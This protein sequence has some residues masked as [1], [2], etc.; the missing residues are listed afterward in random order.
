MTDNQ[1]DSKV[2]PA[3][4]SVTRDSTGAIYVGVSSG[5]LPG[6]WIYRDGG[7]D[8]RMLWSFFDEMLSA[9]KAPTDLDVV[10]RRCWEL[11]A[12]LQREAF[13]RQSNE[14]AYSA[15]VQQ[16][17][18]LRAEVER[19]TGCLERANSQAEHFERSWYLR[20]DELDDARAEVKALRKDAERYRWLREQHEGRGDTDPDALA[21]CVFNQDLAPVS[22]MRGHLD[23][24][25]DEAMEAS[26]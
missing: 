14:S 5:R 11:E 8:E 13:R 16:N 19:L 17:T 25:I 21:F 10:T 26:Q 23:A 9:S 6:V 12:E 1:R 3:G 7:Q 22:C 20:G 18:A 2:A 24:A 15:V 4:W